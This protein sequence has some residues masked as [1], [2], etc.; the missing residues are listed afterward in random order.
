MTLSS[1]NIFFRGGII[2]AAFSLGIAIAGGIFSFPAFPASSA[3]ATLRSGGIIRKLLENLPQS[4]ASPSASVPFWAILGAVAYSFISIILIYYFFEKTQSPE[5]LFFGFFV[6]SLSFEIARIAIPLKSAFFFPARYFITASRVLLFGR[7]FGLFSFFAAGVY[8]AGFDVQ[9]Q[10]NVFLMLIL[11][12]MII[13]FN[14]P[15]DSLVWDSTLKML[16]AYGSMFI[17]VDLGILAVTAITFFISSYIRE[18]KSYIYIGIG[19]LLVFIGR[20][21][22]LGSDTWITLIPG[23][24]I[25]IAGT[26]LVCSK[27]HREYLW[28]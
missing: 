15:I 18:S 25:L 8:A 1:R 28:L 24:L 13:A 9:K 4:L 5:I 10:K 23:L 27:L 26:W 17:M 7:Y 6:I 22:L 3:A 11:A 19:G 12:A 14:V 20:S 21:I 16:N 2:L